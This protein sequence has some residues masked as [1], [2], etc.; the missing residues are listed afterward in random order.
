MRI[1][2]DLYSKKHHLDVLF[3]EM[4]FV[5]FFI[6]HMEKT[7]MQV[8]NELR[9]LRQTME[10]KRMSVMKRNGDSLGMNVSHLLSRK[11]GAYIGNFMNYIIVFSLNIKVCRTYSGIEKCSPNN[12]LVFSSQVSLWYTLAPSS[13]V[14]VVVVHTFLL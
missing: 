9:C 5:A 4:Q 7:R 3:K 11:S 1:N 2:D 13:I 14:V 6:F 8:K 12:S 10:T